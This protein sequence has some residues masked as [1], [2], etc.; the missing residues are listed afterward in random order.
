[1]FISVTQQA[2]A[3]LLSPAGAAAL[4]AGRVHREAS[5]VPPALLGELRQTLAELSRTDR[6][7]A[8][9]SYSSNGARDDLRAALTCKP[10]INDDRFYALYERLDELRAWLGPALGM[11]LGTGIECTFVVYPAGGYYQRHIDSLDGEPGS[12]RRALSFICYLNAP[13]AWAARDGG[14]L[15][16]EECGAPPREI[17]PEGGSLVLFDSKRVWHEVLPTRRERACLVGW[18]HH[19]APDAE[20]T[21]IGNT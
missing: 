10:D 1:M 7:R 6:F 8:G 13:G 3:A 11:P 16:V 4:R 9:A 19:T 15:R 21:S 12:G 20:Q 14:A 5:F 2:C 17:L 18:F